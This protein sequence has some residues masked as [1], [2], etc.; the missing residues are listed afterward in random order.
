AAT[1]VTHPVTAVLLGFRAYDTLLEIAVLLL[2][3]TATWSLHAEL[4]AAPEPPIGPMQE[5]LVQ[6][7]LPLMILVAGHLL[8][9]GS[10]GPGGAFQAGAV[11]AA[12]GV[13]LR[14][15]LRPLPGWRHP[16]R[17]RAFTVLGLVVFLAVGLATMSDGPLLA[18]RGEQAALSIL[19]IEAAAAL[20]I[21]AILAA[22]F[23][24]RPP[25]KSPEQAR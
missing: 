12:G 5:Q 20:S 6:V 7:L 16:A 4:P 13:L 9:V 24:R 23:V 25:D 11:L 2:A 3:L 19:L 17:Y 8:W 21:G 22:L 18:Y 10:K 1:G 15:S 14:L